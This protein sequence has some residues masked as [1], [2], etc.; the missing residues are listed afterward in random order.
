MILTTKIAYLL[1]TEHG[2]YEWKLSAK[3]G[4]KNT[5]FRIELEILTLKTKTFKIVSLLLNIEF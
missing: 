1:G 3:P 4:K 5:N 2:A